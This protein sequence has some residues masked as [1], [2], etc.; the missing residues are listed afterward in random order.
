[1]TVHALVG[2]IRSADPDLYDTS[3]MTAELTLYWT[4]AGWDCTG[5]QLSGDLLLETAGSYTVWNYGQT[6][7]IDVETGPSAWI[8]TGGSLV[9]RDVAITRNG[10]TT[11]VSMSVERLDNPAGMAATSETG[12]VYLAYSEEAGVYLYFG[13]DMVLTIFSPEF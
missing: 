8:D 3:A 9:L 7:S 10:E 13:R 11:N 12:S 4:G 5:V 6:Q 1:M 2:E